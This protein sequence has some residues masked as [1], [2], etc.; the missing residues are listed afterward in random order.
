LLAWFTTASAKGSKMTTSKKYI[1]SKVVLVIVILIAI[2]LYAL[3]TKF[4]LDESYSGEVGTD[5]Q[6]GVGSNGLK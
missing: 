5:Y 6:S 2:I 1:T 4:I 3:L